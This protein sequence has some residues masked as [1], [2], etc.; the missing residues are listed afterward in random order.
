M[1][2]KFVCSIYLSPILIHASGMS[3]VA[4]PI[5]YCS[6]RSSSKAREQR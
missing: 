1:A 6:A 3:I 2:P 4:T 5:I